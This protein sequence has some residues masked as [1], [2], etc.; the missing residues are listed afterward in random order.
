MDYHSQPPPQNNKNEGPASISAGTGAHLDDSHNIF[1]TIVTHPAATAHHTR[2]GGRTSGPKSMTIYAGAAPAASLPVPL[3]GP[4][5][6]SGTHTT[7]TPPPSDVI[8]GGSTIGATTTSDS[9]ANRT[10]QNDRG[11][12][13][14]SNIIGTVKCHETLSLRSDVVLNSHK[15]AM[16]R[17][18][19]SATGLGGKLDWR[20]D[21]QAASASFARAGGTAV[22]K[23][24]GYGDKGGREVGAGGG[25]LRNVLCLYTV[26]QDGE[27]DRS[28]VLC[29]VLRKEI[30]GV[31]AGDGGGGGGHGSNASDD[32]EL[33]DE[34]QGGGANKEQKPQKILGQHTWKFTDGQFEINEVQGATMDEGQ[35]QE[36]LASAVIEIERRARMHSSGGGTTIGRLGTAV[37]LSLT[38]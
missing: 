26:K 18:F 28:K 36:V 7:P 14:A 19:V 5:G 21:V 2:A 4:A 9:R 33:S 15:Y 35:V 30:A 31:A 3:P 37:L 27:L 29:R 34:K 12:S 23:E 10:S 1:M 38:A 17:Q 25:G 22:V 20:S 13:T 8:G 24:E 6:R 32:Q 16:D 11:A